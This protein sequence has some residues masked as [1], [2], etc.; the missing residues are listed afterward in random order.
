LAELLNEAQ[1]DSANPMVLDRPAADEL[2][3]VKNLWLTDEEQSRLLGAIQ[4]LI[5]QGPANLRFSVTDPVPDWLEKEQRENLPD[6]LK[7]PKKSIRL[8]GEKLGPWTDILPGLWRFFYVSPIDRAGKPIPEIRGLVGHIQKVE[9]AST[10]AELQVISSRGYWRGYAFLNERHLY[11][12]CTLD[13]AYETAFF[14]ANAPDRRNSIMVGVGTA[15]ERVPRTVPGVQG[16]LFFGEKW[17]SSKDEAA[18]HL[19]LQLLFDRAARGEEIADSEKETFC[20][21]YINNDDL[22]RNHRKMYDYLQKMK[23]NDEPGFPWRWLHLVYP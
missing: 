18:K 4:V 10:S 23:V 12:F 14:Q 13:G 15:L 6:V 16:F 9:E 20:V 17:G 19:A 5:N 3:K 1:A 21:T 11:M 8:Q 2:L 22:K 7:N